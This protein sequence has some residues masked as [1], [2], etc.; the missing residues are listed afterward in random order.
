MRLS[1]WRAVGVP[2]LFS[3]PVTEDWYEVVTFGRSTGIPVPGARV[4]GCA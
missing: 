3:G 2:A 4:L 1:V